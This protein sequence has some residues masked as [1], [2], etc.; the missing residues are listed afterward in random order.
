MRVS[1]I[2]DHSDLDYKSP[3]M[4]DINSKTANWLAG[5]GNLIS[6]LWKTGADC[7]SFCVAELSVYVIQYGAGEMFF[8]P[9]WR[10]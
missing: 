5:L 4:F 2:R 7:L 6:V 8:A 9:L 1:P 3:N 10:D